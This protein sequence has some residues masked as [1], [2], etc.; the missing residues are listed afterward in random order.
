MLPAVQASNWSQGQIWMPAAEL[1]GCA[2]VAV[3]LASDT[4][5][6]VALA[7]ALGA[8]TGLVPTHSCRFGAALGRGHGYLGPEAGSPRAML[9][10]DGEG[11]RQQMQKPMKPSGETSVGPVVALLVIDLLS[12]E[13]CWGPQGAASWGPWQS[14]Q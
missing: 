10:E 5:L 2:C 9:A 14:A 4:H 1:S 7:L 11:L 8:W 6:A 3:G 13:S 12:G